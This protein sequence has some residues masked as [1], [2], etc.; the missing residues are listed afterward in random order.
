MKLKITLIFYIKKKHI[1]KLHIEYFLVYD[2]LK[3]RAKIYRLLLHAS[4]SQQSMGSG[5]PQ[6]VNRRPL[7]A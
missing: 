4:S 6:A 3:C 1:S 7:I 5:M 2:S